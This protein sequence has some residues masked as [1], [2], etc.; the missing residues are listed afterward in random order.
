M[1]LSRRYT[2][3]LVREDVTDEG[4][5]VKEYPQI[6]GQ[7]HQ[8]ENELRML[9]LDKSY[10][11][12]TVVAEMIVDK[13]CNGIKQELRDPNHALKQ[14]SKNEEEDMVQIIVPLRP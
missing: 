8:S 3:T 7:L 12:E 5:V 4:Y 9:Q 13:L 14:D 1:G 6:I 2:L 10:L 11:N